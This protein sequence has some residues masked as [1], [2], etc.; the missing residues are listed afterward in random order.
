[1][2]SFLIA[3]TLLLV[4]A[5]S[6]PAALAAGTCPTTLEWSGTIWPP[7]FHYHDLSCDGGFCLCGEV[8]FSSPQGDART[9]WCSGEGGNECDLGLTSE[10]KPVRLGVCPEGCRSKLTVDS[11]RPFEGSLGLDC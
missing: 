9:C 5:P 11:L 1:M 4:A 2:R 8:T 3:C 6:A 10:G 7:S